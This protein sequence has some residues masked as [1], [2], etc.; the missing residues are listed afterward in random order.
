MAATV[1]SFGIQGVALAFGPLALVQPLVSTEML[2]A[3]PVVAYSNRRRLTRRGI[4][5]RLGVASW[6][7]VF[8]AVSPP[9]GGVAD[10]HEVDVDRGRA[11]LAQGP[12]RPGA[13]DGRRVH[14][15]QPG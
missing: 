4:T 2:F 12:G 8:M 5:G 1:V 6:I 10:H 3:L 9:A 15:A 7:A 13:E 11:R 14:A